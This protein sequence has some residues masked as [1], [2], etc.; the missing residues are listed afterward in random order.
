MATIPNF[1]DEEGE[2]KSE[3]YINSSL[4]KSNSGLN[5][6]NWK[7]G[8]IADQS[9][10]G[11]FISQDFKMAYIYYFVDD[12]AEQ[13]SLMWK[14]KSFLEEKTFG[15]IHQFTEFDIH[16]KDASIGLASW[17]AG[18]W[19]IHQA[20][21]LNI[22]MI[23]SGGILFVFPGFRRALHSWLQ[24]AVCVIIFFMSII[25]TRGLIGLLWFFGFNVVERV[26]T[27]L[28]YANCIVQ[29]TS[30][31]LHKFG[32]YNEGREK[33]LSADEA[34]QATAGTDRL[35]ARL[36]IISLGGFL[37]LW[38]SF[39]VRPI[40][41]MALAS[42]LGL[43]CLL[44]FSRYLLPV[45][46]TLLIKNHK[47][48]K[49][50][51]IGWLGKK[52]TAVFIQ[53]PLKAAIWINTR[54]GLKTT[55]IAMIMVVV[56]LTIGTIYQIAWPHRNL[57]IR[58]KPLEFI[59]GTLVYKTSKELN[60]PGYLGFDGLNFLLEPSWTKAEGIYDPRFIQRVQ[61][62]TKGVSNF[63]KELGVYQ[64]YSIV[65]AVQRISSQSFH[66]PLPTSEKEAGYAF[67]NIENKLPPIVF[68]AFY[69]H[70]GIRLIVTTSADDSNKMFALREAVEN[71]V[72]LN[73]PEIKISSFGRVQTYP[74]ADR[75][76]REGKPWNIIGDQILITIFFMVWFL[77]SW[78]RFRKTDLTIR[79][80]WGAL[81]MNI[82]MW[83]ATTGLALIMV[84]MGIPLDISTAA[85][86]A[87]AIN[88]TSDFSFVF[89]EAFQNTL[90]ET[91]NAFSA[92][93]AALRQKGAVIIEDAFLNARCFLPLWLFSTFIPIQRIG[94]MMV[95]MLVLCLIGTLVI[96]PSVL[97]ITVRKPEKN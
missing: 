62:I 12:D 11:I 38:W 25:W 33:G 18:R 6:G 9:V 50:K 21:L 74:E 30:F 29:G 4:F 46:S 63:P 58:S 15:W 64:T 68:R 44:V 53:Q 22:L 51:E 91:K 27:L 86:S 72:R 89:L 92:M 26:Y 20:L 35:I 76:I 48:G 36:V 82:P 67:M 70:N 14:V 96:L 32:A 39:G 54:F 28:S 87:F 69:Y 80:F 88:A 19:I 78:L 60:R 94:L 24:A 37:T 23:I 34:W 3:Y 65:K 77:F 95:I 84:K 8:V 71:Y 79:P 56:V 97:A 5:I 45:L 57:V 66:K 43:V 40:A 41:D 31:S 83:F 73:F 90:G 59:P 85:I 13:M 7:K 49:T 1:L 16:P 47:V 81:A 93:I 42:A 61:M 52:I 17:I 75:E 55:A 2:L 10:Y